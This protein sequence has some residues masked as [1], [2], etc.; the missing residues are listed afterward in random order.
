MLTSSKKNNYEMPPKKR[1]ARTT[2]TE[3]DCPELHNEDPSQVGIA[4][5]HITTDIT[6]LTHHMPQTVQSHTS[7]K[8]HAAGA[9]TVGLEGLPEE[10]LPQTKAFVT[11]TATTDLI[12]L[13][14]Q[15]APQVN[16]GLQL[17]IEDCKDYQY[18]K[19]EI[20]ATITEDLA[21]LHHENVH[22]RLKQGS[23][24]R[25][26]VATHRVQAMQQQVA[27]ERARQAELQQ[28]INTIHQQEQEQ[29]PPLQQPLH[30]QILRQVH[31]YQPL[32]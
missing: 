23:I 10:Q 3:A 20:E 5:N 18:S 31:Q 24:M 9:N 27:Q 28:A 12:P 22:L 14:L 30:H 4:S 29:E 11:G 25:W 7:T 2:Q 16:Q 1:L 13:S 26:R 19:E 21:Y 15:Q 17:E 6:N 8:S 32:P